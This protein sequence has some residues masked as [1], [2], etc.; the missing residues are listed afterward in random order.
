MILS[1]S[2]VLVYV[3]GVV[4]GLAV[5][6]LWRAGRRPNRRRVVLRRLGRRD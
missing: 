3:V 6:A 5:S 2:D 1:A 4:V